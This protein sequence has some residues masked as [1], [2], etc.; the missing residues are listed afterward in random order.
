MTNDPSFKAL[1][2]L[3]ASTQQNQAGT[4][5]AKATN[6]MLE[7]Y[8]VP[9]S[10]DATAKFTGQVLCENCHAMNKPDGNYCRN[11]GTA[12]PKKVQCSSCNSIV[13]QDDKFC[14]QCGNSIKQTTK[15]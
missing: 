4:G 7:D 6:K 12:M 11:C 2:N 3:M 14:G 10:I 15:N 1:D 8:L 13:S 9:G 5:L